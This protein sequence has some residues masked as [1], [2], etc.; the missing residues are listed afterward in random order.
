[1]VAV[2]GVDRAVAFVL[3]R[4]ADDEEQA[5]DP[6]HQPLH[7]G[8]DRTT[9]STLSD[10]ML[11]QCAALRK[12]VE[13]HHEYLGVCTHCVDARGEHQREAWPC[14]TI[15]ALCA[16]WSCHPDYL[17]AMAAPTAP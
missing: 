3:A 10:R 5:R 13:L 15:R 4:I 2:S 16:I 14:A 11:D 17:D 8:V 6:E 7:L 12:V 1:M 9:M